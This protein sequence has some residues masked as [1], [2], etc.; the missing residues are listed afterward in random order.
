MSCLMG[1]HLC[2][3]FTEGGGGGMSLGYTF[4]TKTAADYSNCWITTS[5]QEVGDSLVI[6]E[7]S[8]VN[9]AVSVQNCR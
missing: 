7:Q 8:F 2:F 1:S 6:L 9:Q 4:E 3:R 5:L